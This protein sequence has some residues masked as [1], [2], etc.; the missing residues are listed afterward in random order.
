MTHRLQYT[1]PHQ[2]HPHCNADTL[3]E[4]L[5]RLHVKHLRTSAY[6]PRTNG[7]L[8]KFNGTFGLMLTRLC[9]TARHR[10]DEFLDEAIF[11]YR[12]RIHTT[13]KQS[14]FFLLYG[15]QPAIPGDD[16]TP[17]VLDDSVPEDL[18]EI[19]AR[20]LESI[21]QHRQAAIERSKY[22]SARSKILFDLDVEKD[23]LKE[24]EWVKLLNEKRMK[25]E[26]KWIGPFK[27]RRQT[28]L[29]TYQLE[30][31]TGQIKNDLVHRS[32]LDRYRVDPNKPPERLWTSN[33]PQEGEE[34]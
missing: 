1:I 18:P 21:G 25:F 13:T 10:W 16:T 30:D 8:E 26:P 19:R 3:E 14:P 12:I 22:S 29:G 31:P 2:R 9:G 33:N 28:P 32:R 34:C 5:K 15:V 4:Y 20:L 7:M 6:H 24:G 11:S 17:Y 27:I 23:E